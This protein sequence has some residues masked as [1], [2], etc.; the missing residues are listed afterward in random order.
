[1]KRFITSILV[2]AVLSTLVPVVAS[3]A[4]QPLPSPDETHPLVMQQAAA[5]VASA[6][7]GRLSPFTAAART[8]AVGGNG[9]LRAEVFGFALASS[10][11]DPTIGYPSWNFSLLSTVAFFGLHVNDGGDLAADSGWGVWNSSQLSGL[12][13]A[14]HGAGTRVVLTVI[15][16]DFSAGTPH[17]CAGLANRATTVSQTV[18]QVVAKGVDGVNLDYEGLGGSCANGQSPRSA[19]TDLAHQ[20]RAALPA[21]SYLSVDTY[22]SSA[23]DPVGFFDVPGLGANVDSIFV[24]AY[25]LE[26]SNWRHAPLSCSS[27]CLGP[28]GPLTGYYYNDTNVAS[29]YTA[30]VP[31]SKVILGVPYYGRKSCV[32]SPTANQYPTAAVTADGYRDAIGEAGVSTVQPGSYVV[33]HDANDVTGQERWDTWFNTALNCT[34]ELYWDDATSLGKKYDLVNQDQLRGVGIWNLNFGGGSAELWNELAAKFG[35]TTAWYSLGGVLTSGAD[36]ASWGPNRLDAFVRGTDMA[37]YHRWWDGT[38]WQP[39][40]S[41]GGVAT[42]DP[43]AVAWGNGRLDLFVRGTDN[44]LH[45]RS[46]SGAWSDWQSLGGVF[47]SG[48]DASSWGPNRLDVFGRGTDFALYHRAWTGAAWSDW[49]SLGGVLTSDP[50]A[51]SWGS[52]HLDVFGRG[53]DN[54]LYHLG[55]NGSWGSWESLGGILVSGPDAASCGT[56]HLDVFVLGSDSAL[57]QRGYNA[58]WGSWTRLG[59]RWTADPGAVCPPGGT[60]VSLLERGLDGALWFTGVPAS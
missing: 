28:T 52:A 59:G 23:G 2:F 50:T 4:A 6:P 51:I 56:G 12:L 17:M 26:Y 18:A 41:L 54:A 7:L 33:H 44:A 43:T 1:M 5:Q 8:P 53:T 49:Q 15:L 24:M 45:T 21:G 57:Y 34:R 47:T 13:A 16:Q 30:V 39:W 42:S 58:A 35:T 27:F 31:A 37:I 38:L 55:W 20:L 25:D 36:A 11:S 22:A 32:S 40:E 14:A 48:P 3:A 19:M 46:W 9:G 10:L 29:Q 60:S